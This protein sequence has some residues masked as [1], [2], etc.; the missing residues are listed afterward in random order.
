MSM[1]RM[2]AIPDRFRRIENLHIV[3]WLIKDMSWALLWKPIGLFMLFPTIIV[4]ML[5]TWQTRKIRSEL[6]H[7]LAV[8][9]WISANGYWMIV[10]FFYPELDHLRYYAAI[11]F[12]IGILI[13][14]YYYLIDA[15]KHK[16]KENMVPV[17][18]GIPE[19]IVHLAEKDLS[20]N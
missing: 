4:A 15:P 9:F 7:N 13:I 17:T 14:A 3:L 16:G 2:Y 19:D 20:K 5:I 10:E 18:I 12:S 8:V 11:P 1:P 6:L